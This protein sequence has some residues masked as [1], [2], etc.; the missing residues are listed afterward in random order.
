MNCRAR[1]RIV[2]DETNYNV[3]IPFTRLSI[4][5]LNQSININNFSNVFSKKIIKFMSIF[6]LE[7]NLFAKFIL[8]KV[9]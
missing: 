7:F 3:R 9:K 6:V 4:T 1:D 5:L 8:E 2:I